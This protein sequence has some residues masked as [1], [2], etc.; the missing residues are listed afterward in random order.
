VDVVVAGE[1]LIDLIPRRGDGPSAGR[2]GPVPA[3]LDALPGGSPANVAI[4]AARLGRVTGFLGVL[5]DDGFGAHLRAHLAREGVDL[6]SVAPTDRPTTLAVAHLDDHGVASYRF[7]LEGTSAAVPI[8]GPERGLA[9][10]AVLHASFGAL[11][12]TTDPAGRALV[13]LLSREHGHRLVSLDPNVRPIA[14]GA[15]DAYRPALESVVRRTDLVKVSDED[16]ATLAPGE[17]PLT[18]AARWV[19]DGPALVVVTRGR[20]G[21]VAL[22]ADGA[23]L[24]V[25][26]PSVTV[27]DTVG[28]GDAFTAGLLVAL[29]EREVRTR[30]ALEHLGDAELAETLAF[31]ARVAA[32]TC[33][34]LGADPPRRAELT[35]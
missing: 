9:D 6:T 11:S 18:V 34:R 7:Y 30:A 31:A 5:S 35:G 20:D 27:A 29:V 22:R 28:A 26:A 3:R 1:A 21:A 12:A 23:R 13:E 32:I 25:G 33:T 19:T 4:G 14:I 8:V 2:S 17:D 16:L 24:E 15:V 10:G